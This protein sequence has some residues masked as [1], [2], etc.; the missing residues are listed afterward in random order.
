M[1]HLL[2]LHKFPMKISLNEHT[3]ARFHSFSQW[4]FAVHRF[5]CGHFLA[6]EEQIKSD[7][8][9]SDSSRLFNQSKG[10][11]VFGGAPMQVPA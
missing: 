1:K 7:A 10:A 5:Y 8:N 3:L 11:S 6:A 9:V 2:I 4:P